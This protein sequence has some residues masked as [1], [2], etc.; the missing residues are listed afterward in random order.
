MAHNE[1]LVFVNF[2]ILENFIRQLL[3]TIKTLSHTSKLLIDIVET[4]SHVLE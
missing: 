2:L 4:L 3:K 1:S